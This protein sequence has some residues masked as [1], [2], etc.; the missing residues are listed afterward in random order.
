[1]TVLGMTTQIAVEAITHVDQLFGDDDVERVRLA[2][3]DTRQ[4]N[5]DHM[6]ISTRQVRVGATHR[7][8]KPASQPALE[9]WL[10]RRDP[11]SLARQLQAFTIPLRDG[12]HAQVD[13]F[14]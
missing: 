13:I 3:V 4:V 12:R 6:F 14:S 10:I 8:A 1:M 9:R 2:Q 7:G 11:Q 5:Q